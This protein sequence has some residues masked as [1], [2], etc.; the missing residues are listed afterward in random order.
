MIK[1]QGNDAYYVRLWDWIWDNQ[2]QLGSS[3]SQV[4]RDVY[5]KYFV[6]K[7]GKGDNPLHSMVLDAYFGNECIGFVS[8]YLRYIKVWN[9]YLGVDNHHWSIHFPE[10]IQRLDDVRPLDLLEWTTVGHV[11]LVD[12]VEGVSNG[13]LKLDVSQCSGL[14]DLKGPM[15]NGGVFLAKA[16]EQ[17]GDNHTWFTI[18]GIVPVGGELQV[19]RMPGLQYASPRYPYTPPGGPADVVEY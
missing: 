2:E 5:N 19:R 1:G 3:R 9:E 13:R 18:S 17:G 4:L 11:A 16:V 7:E 10:K 8:N 6:R 12:D 15:S 14:G